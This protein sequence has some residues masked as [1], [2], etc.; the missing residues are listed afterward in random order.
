MKKLML[1]SIFLMGIITLSSCGDNAPGIELPEE[2]GKTETETPKSEMQVSII[3]GDRKLKAVLYDNSAAKDLY[4]RLPLEIVLSDFNN[5]TEK[6]FY[7]DPNLDMADVTRG[8]SPEPGDITIYEPWGNVAIFC[9]K[10]SYSRDLIKIG[11][12][13]DDGINALS[14]PGDVTV[15]IER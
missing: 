12:V 3:V 7:P 10:W 4:S 2:E 5:V 11:H 13:S 1:I 15:R 14:I 8:C 9:K 6:I